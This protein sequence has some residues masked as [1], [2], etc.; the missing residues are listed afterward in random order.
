MCGGMDVYV[1]MCEDVV[2]IGYIGME[3]CV[4]EGWGVCKCGRMSGCLG[5][6]GCMCGCVWMCVDVVDIGYVW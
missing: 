3:V 1:W 5:V 2:D 4:I 6:W